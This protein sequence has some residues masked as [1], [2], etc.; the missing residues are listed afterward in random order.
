MPR[1]LQESLLGTRMGSE[2]E[3]TVRAGEK[4]IPVL[5]GINVT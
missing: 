1:Q 2:V 4:L 3:S 5:G